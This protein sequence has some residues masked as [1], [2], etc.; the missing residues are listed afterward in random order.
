V[1]RYRATIIAVLPVEDQY[2]QLLELRTGLRRFL[3]WSEQQARAEGLTPAQHQLLLA[4]KG[5]QGPSEPTVSDLARLLLLR[6]HSVVG[7]IDRAQAAGLVRRRRDPLHPALVR[8]TLTGLGEA[9][10]DALT[11]T[12]LAE[13]SR[14]APAMEQLWAATGELAVGHHPA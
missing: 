12:H 6:H 10:L 4:V 3:N 1:S 11:E 9:K 7:L 2:T 14:L 13:L 8:L 5:H